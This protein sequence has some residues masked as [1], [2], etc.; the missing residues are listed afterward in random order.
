MSI[1][2]GTENRFERVKFYFE[3]LLRN[4]SGSRSIPRIKISNLEEDIGLR[5]EEICDIV[6]NGK[7]CLLSRLSEYPNQAQ[8]IRNW[9]R[10]TKPKAKYR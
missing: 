4:K 7:I 9:N 3:E 1:E 6:K 2:N 5:F 8:I 10:P